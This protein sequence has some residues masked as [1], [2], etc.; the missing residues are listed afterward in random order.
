MDST[1]QIK[2]AVSVCIQTYQQVKYIKECLEGV[3][4]QQT[5]FTY[6]IIIGEDESD[7][8]TREIC[9]EYAERYPD[10][11]KLFLRKRSDVIYVEGHATGRYNLIINIKAASGTYIAICEGDDY[12]TDPFKLQKQFDVM[13]QK[14]GV[15]LCFHR[16]DI[17]N[18]SSVGIIDDIY[19]YPEK[20]GVINQKDLFKSQMIPTCSMFIRHESIKT[21]PLFLNHVMGLDYCMQ[22]YLANK[23]DIYFISDVMGTYRYGAG[24]WSRGSQRDKVIHGI[25][26]L[27]HLLNHLDGGHKS[28][29][30]TQLGNL[31]VSNNLFSA[32]DSIKKVGPLLGQL[33][34]FWLRKMINSILF[35]SFP[36]LVKST[37]QKEQEID[38]LIEKLNKKNNV[39]YQLQESNDRLV[40][41]IKERED[42]FKEMTE[43]KEAFEH[44]YL[45]KVQELKRLN[46]QLSLK[47]SHISQLQESIAV[48][49]RR[50]KELDQSYM[51]KLDLKTN[52]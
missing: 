13:E 11:V 6:E 38:L 28:E 41:T 23:G 43:A 8:G 31:I 7:D 10:K 3:L 37:S 52:N 34:E 14:K 12:W 45:G 40:H 48:Y 27:V 51:R 39:A 18:K 29:L 50:T 5:S 42:N 32:T 30:L 1:D 46:V 17:I 44:A 16:T 33:N 22:L 15:S 21:L 2:P 36:R 26:D 35:V 25:H 49:L 19:I 20:P 4:M 24:T 47:Y 9:M